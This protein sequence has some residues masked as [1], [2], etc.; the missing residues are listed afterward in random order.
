MA[1]ARR[2]RRILLSGPVLVGFGDVFDRSFGDPSTPR[3][4]PRVTPSRVGGVLLPFPCPHCSAVR[5][6][7]VDRKKG[8]GYY[9]DE[10][11]FSWCPACRKRF[12][13]DT[14]GMPLEHK[15][16]P[17][18]THAPARIE[19]SGKVSV[20]GLLTSGDGLDVLGVTR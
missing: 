10:R 4:Y 16:E 2:P 9:D 14:K 11:G 3:P 20:V 8:A 5:P 12:V 19:R 6:V 7:V 13:V 18:A 15:L 17:G 1:L